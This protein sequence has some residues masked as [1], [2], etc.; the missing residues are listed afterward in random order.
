[1]S[2]GS[3]I[4]SIYESNKGTFHYVRVQPETELLTDGVV[5]NDAPAG[6][7]NSQLKAQVSKSRRGY[8]LKTRGIYV[9]FLEGL[10]P[11]GYEDTSRIFLPILTPAAFAAYTATPQKQ[12]TYLNVTV[13][14]VGESEEKFG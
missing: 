10:A 14:V 11:D 1:M 5:V 7:I 12:L 9:K 6:P 8:G 13:V 2:A 4:D 3:F